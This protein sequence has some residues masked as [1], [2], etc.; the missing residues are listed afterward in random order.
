MTFTSRETEQVRV[1]LPKDVLDLASLL[2]ARKERT[3]S[4]GVAEALRV[5]AARI[6]VRA[7]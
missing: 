5:H 6:E 4:E 3:L 7:A 1:R 2:A